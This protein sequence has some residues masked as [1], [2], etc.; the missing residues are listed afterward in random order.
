MAEGGNGDVALVFL[1]LFID[2]G[3]RELHGS[4]YGLVFLQQFGRLVLPCLWNPAR[5]DIGFLISVM[6]LLRFGAW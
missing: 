6:P 3:V 2:L 1:V 4:V 5:L